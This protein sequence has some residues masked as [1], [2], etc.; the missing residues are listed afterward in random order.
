MGTTATHPVTSHLLSCVGRKVVIVLFFFQYAPCWIVPC[1]WSSARNSQTLL[2]VLW[3][4]QISPVAAWA[5][6]II[7][8][9]SVFA[10]EGK[11]QFCST[12]QKKD[13]LCHVILGHFC[14]WRAL[15]LQHSTAIF[16][17][18]LEKFRAQTIQTALS[19]S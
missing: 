15:S 10:Q 19:L 16:T 3:Q 5:A 9:F 13:T 4:C 6:I 2:L 7:N 17:N 14:N 8:S 1:Q 12:K 11:G 18:M